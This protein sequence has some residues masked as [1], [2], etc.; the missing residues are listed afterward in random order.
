[1][2]HKDQETLKLLQTFRSDLEAFA[3]GCL[4]I[5]DKAGNVL[6]F[7]GFNSAQKY[8][9]KRLEEQKAETGKIRALVLKGRQQGVST[10]TAIRYY[11]HSSLFRGVQVYILSHEQSAS[12]NLF[13][14]VDRFQVNNPIRPHTGVSNVKELEFDR[15]DSS[16]HVA[17]AGQKGGGRSKTISL[18]HG[19]EVAFWQSAQ[20]HFASS[21]QTVPDMPGTE[22]IL[23]STGNGAS[24][25]FYER[26]Q[27][28]VAGNGDYLPIFIPWFWQE[29]YTRP[30]PADFELSDEPGD[31]G[32]SEREY[33]K[34]FDLSNNQMAWRR[35]KVAELRSVQLFDQEYPASPEMAF[36]SADL[37]RSFILPISV[38]RARKRKGIQGA[39]PLIIGAD[40]SGPGKDRFAVSARQGPKVLWTMHRQMPETQEA[41]LWLASLI[42]EHRPDRMFID[43]GNIGHAVY[44]LLKNI[45]DN[46]GRSIYA[47]IIRGVN[48]GSPS[49]A[50]LAR[51]K[52]PGPK[53][54]RAEMWDRSREW[55]ELEEG[56][57]LPDMDA[58][59][60]DATAPRIKPLLNGDF[61]IESK[62]EMKKRGVRS[63]DLWDSV[64]LTFAEVE[65]ILKAERRKPS[66]QTVERAAQPVIIGPE[67]GI[68]SFPAIGGENSWMGL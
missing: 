45:R 12:D 6:Q 68:P 7:P 2:Q 17:T 65:R 14:M 44:S 5:R 25:E 23:E 39:G 53:N 32:V 9:H 35:A 63:P 59:Q 54:R 67:N 56:V 34:L 36:A 1:M 42:D 30:A 38:L 64:I 61:L 52:V 22:I 58:L 51:P 24:G 13:K 49:Q 11:H 20:D 29:E 10:Y 47:D 16:Y 60:A 57:S 3:K 48:F 62:E 26:W 37:K 43:L 46:R 4:K 18:F 8:L 15:L 31:N 66:T 21:V 55:L 41:V 33:A 28:A 19:S 27:D 40:P 50:K